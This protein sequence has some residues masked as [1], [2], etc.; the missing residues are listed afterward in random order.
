MPAAP[1][2]YIIIEDPPRACYNGFNTLSIATL[3]K[4]HIHP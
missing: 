1:A 4:E 3:K 2:A